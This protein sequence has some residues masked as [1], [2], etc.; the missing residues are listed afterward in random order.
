[1]KLL[2]LLLFSTLAAC[3]APTHPLTYVDPDDPVWP[4]NPPEQAAR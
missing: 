1:M 3:T 4:I 2:F